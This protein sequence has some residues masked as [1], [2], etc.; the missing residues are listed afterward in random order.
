MITFF[1]NNTNPVEYI[2][3]LKYPSTYD[4]LTLYIFFK[5]YWSLLYVYLY[6]IVRKNYV[7]DNNTYTFIRN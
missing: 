1:G 4:S 5:M 3:V 6:V 7:I 2:N